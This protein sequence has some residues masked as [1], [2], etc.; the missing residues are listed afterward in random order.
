MSSKK[1]AVLGAV[2]I[3]ATGLAACT[4][5]GGN[6][7]LNS[8]AITAY[9][10]PQA[11]SSL[12]MNRKRLAA[13]IAQ[14]AAKQRISNAAHLDTSAITSACQSYELAYRTSVMAHVRPEWRRPDALNNTANSATRN[15]YAAILELFQ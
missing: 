6:T 1:M 2:A 4:S 3:V 13:C 11:K 8:Q 5:T 14:Q 12:G 15:L 9:A 7:S 10:A